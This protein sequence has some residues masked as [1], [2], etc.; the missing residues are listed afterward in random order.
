MPKDKVV[1]ARHQ[2]QHKLELMERYWGA[3]CRI[4]AQ[5]NGLAFCNR[6]LWLIDTMAG[7]G[8]HLSACDPDGAIPGTPLQAVL[9]ARATQA[10]FQGEVVAVRAVEKSRAKASKLSHL[11]APYKG[12]PPFGVDL[13]VDPT[14][15]VEAAPAII[16]EIASEDHPHAGRPRGRGEHAHRSLWFIDPNGVDGIDHRLIASLPRG[17]E[18]IVNLD[19]MAVLRH[20]G[21]ARRGDAQA[22]GRL[23][24]LYSGSDWRSAAAVRPVAIARERLAQLF[25][26]SFPRFALRRAYPLRPSGSQDRY[27]IHLTDAQTAVTAFESALLAAFSAGT[28][29]AGNALSKQQKD[30]AAQGLFAQFAGQTLTMPEMRGV[31]VPW[32][33]VQLRAICVA[34]EQLG[35][36]RWSADT[37]SMEWFAE[38][39]TQPGFGL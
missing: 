35:Y 18:V 33:L 1:E 5:A 32:T 9:A 15:W 11:L 4:L 13:R 14:D 20:L 3:W 37:R 2:T 39:E 29:I 26:D 12:E 21:K 30:L 36:G 24:A 6:R 28:V 8:L 7:R 23:D 31:G 38:R 22:A 17:S 25:A 34:A 27:V 10:R 16:A 19:V